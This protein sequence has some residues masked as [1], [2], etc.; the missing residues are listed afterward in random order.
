MSDP[1]VIALIAGVPGM[2]AAL[3]SLLNSLAIARSSRHL[4]AVKED[5]RQIK[6]N[7]N[8][9][10]AQMVQMAS[11]T[12]HAIGKEEGVQQEA[13]RASDLRRSA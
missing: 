6:E 8:G 7:T 11:T 3:S 5:T 4:A 10:T 12:A 13:K 1:V 9:M 2:F